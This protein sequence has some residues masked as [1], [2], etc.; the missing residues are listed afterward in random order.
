MPFAVSPKLAIAIVLIGGLWL[1]IA[2]IVLFFERFDRVPLH[3]MELLGYL[4]FYVVGCVSVWA[5]TSSF[6]RQ[7]GRALLV[8][9]LYL[10]FIPIGVLFALGGGLFGPFGVVVGGAIAFIIPWAVLRA[11]PKKQGV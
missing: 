4:L 1:P 6:R 10:P 5:F 11:I 9:L 3:P 7:A 2:E 8:I